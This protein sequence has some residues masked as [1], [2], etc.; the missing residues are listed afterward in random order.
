ME[1]AH[2]TSSRLTSKNDPTG[3]IVTTHAVNNSPRRCHYA[4]QRL[5]NDKPQV[6]RLLDILA[7]VPPL[8]WGRDESGAATC[9]TRTR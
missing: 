3:H 8:T 2:P 7:S 4:A 5:S 6:T 1:P 9:G